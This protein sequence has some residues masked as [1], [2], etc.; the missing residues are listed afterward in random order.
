MSLAL[1]K[2]KAAAFGGTLAYEMAR[3]EEERSSWRKAMLETDL[4]G[5]QVRE[6]AES[7]AYAQVAKELKALQSP[8]MFIAQQYQDHMVRPRFQ[9]GVYW[10]SLC[11]QP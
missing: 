6:L 4:I 7:S 8:A 10:R 2:I 9:Y 3:M 11:P 1:E 5:K